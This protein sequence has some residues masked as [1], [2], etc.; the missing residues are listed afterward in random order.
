M[1]YGAE[2]AIPIKSGFLTLRT[3]K[4][5]VE[6]NNSLFSASLELVEERREVATVKMTHYQ[7]RLK[8]GY[9]RGVKQRPLSQGDLVMRKVVGMTRNP[10]WGKLGPNWEGPYKI[11]LVASIGAYYLEDLVENVVPHPWNVNIYDVIIINDMKFCIFMSGSFL[12]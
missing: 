6:K 12:P 2:A 7:Q 8:Q 11:T 10:T 3:D 4:F 1:T 9:D 5:N